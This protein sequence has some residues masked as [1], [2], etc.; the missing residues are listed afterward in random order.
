MV[1]GSASSGFVDTGLQLTTTQTTYTIYSVAVT[2]GTVTL[3]G[4]QA[5]GAAGASDMYL[6]GLLP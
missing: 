3:G 6:I 5:T 2:A 4:N 1:P